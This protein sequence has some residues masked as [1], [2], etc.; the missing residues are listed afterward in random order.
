M[1]EHEWISATEHKP[2]QNGVIIW[3]AFRD[4]FK[5]AVRWDYCDQAWVSAIGDDCTYETSAIKYWMPYQPP[6]PPKV[7]Y[8]FR[9]SRQR[10]LCVARHDGHV[11]ETEDYDFACRVA[12]LFGW[13]VVEVLDDD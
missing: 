11:A 10:Q 4:D 7:R 8:R 13:H 1:N 6:L 12:D 5:H 9:K 3:A 2:P